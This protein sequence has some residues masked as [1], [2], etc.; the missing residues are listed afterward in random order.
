MQEI[1][2]G[3]LLFQSALY[4][5]QSGLLLPAKRDSTEAQAL[6]VD[7]GIL[8]SEVEAIARALDCAGARAG[9]VLLTHSDWDHLSGAFRFEGAGVI[10]SVAYPDEA[11]VRGQQIAQEIDR[12]VVAA[13][14]SRSVPFVLPS[15]A[16]L[17]GSESEIV[18][19]PYRARAFPAPGHT[20]D[21]I[22]LLLAEKGVLF[23]GDYLSPIEIPYAEFRIG[24]YR[25]TLARFRRLLSSGPVE[26]VVPGHGPAISAS[27][28]L[29]ILDAD[30]AYLDRLAEAVRRAVGRG[31]S[32]AEALRAAGDVEVPRL[33][34]DPEILAG[35]ERN[36]RRAVE[37][38]WPAAR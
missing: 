11:A 30:G 32:R 33:G 9:H 36:A 6:L 8:P 10:A 22:A 31:G 37:E 26:R 5:M 18:G 27:E 1:S 7:P 23:A 25:R 15:A 20:A 34:S 13:G 29:G 19:A 38:Y 24:E 21:S 2:P 16:S 4:A 12:C 35:H 28:A 3:V 17:I 14:E